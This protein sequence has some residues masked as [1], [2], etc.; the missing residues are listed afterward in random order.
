M[1]RAIANNKESSVYM[2][3]RISRDAVH[4]FCDRFPQISTLLFI[5]QHKYS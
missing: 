4:S 2:G 1:A 3:D 5:Y